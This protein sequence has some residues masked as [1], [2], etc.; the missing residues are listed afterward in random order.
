[1]FTFR[2]IFYD[3]RHLKVI[4]CFALIKKLNRKYSL[5]ILLVSPLYLLIQ[6]ETPKCK[7]YLLDNLFTCN[8]TFWLNSAMILATLAKNTYFVMPLRIYF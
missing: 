2:Q 4:F 7:Q 3:K 1:M 5:Q 8:R 6:P